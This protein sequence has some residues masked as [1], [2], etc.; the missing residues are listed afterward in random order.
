M[1]YLCISTAPVSEAAAL[2]RQLVDERL[3]ACVNIVPGI[4]SVYRWKGEVQHDREALL[5]IKTSDEALPQLMR[6][7]PDLHPYD[8]P[9][10]VA[11]NPS[12]VHP[13]Y[14]R[15]VDSESNPLSSG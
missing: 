3:A 9:E 4:T 6:E 10:I 15:W 14:A 5:V 7:L 8:V 2:A 12:C 13:E 11:L 1:I